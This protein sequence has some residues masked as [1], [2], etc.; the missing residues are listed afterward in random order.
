MATRQEIINQVLAKLDEITVFDD[1]QQVPTV[2][3][4]DKLLDEATIDMLRNAPMHMLLPTKVNTESSTLNHYQ[5]TDGW[6]YIGLPTDFLRLYSFKMT[7]W[8]R[9][10]TQAISIQSPKYKL[11]KNPYTRGGIAKPVV[12][13]NHLT[14]VNAGINFSDPD[15]EIT[16]E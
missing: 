5:N 16:S 4:V 9:P 14:E 1:A 6:G 3:M 2:A 15:V 8:K 12:A 10:V 7:V 13:V 11:Q